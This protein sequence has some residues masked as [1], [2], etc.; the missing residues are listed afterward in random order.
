[1]SSVFHESYRNNQEINIS[2]ESELAITQNFYK[3]EGQF[4]NNLKELNLFHCPY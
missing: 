1:M 2:S 3:D 4:S